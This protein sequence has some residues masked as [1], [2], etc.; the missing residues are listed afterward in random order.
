MRIMN[1]SKYNGETKEIGKWCEDNNCYLHIT[2]NIFGCD[3]YRTVFGSH[4]N[5]S[6]VKILRLPEGIHEISE[7]SFIG[8]NWDDLETIMVPTSIMKIEQGSMRN[9]VRLI[10]PICT[11]KEV[12]NSLIENHT[13]FFIEFD[14]SIDI[15]E[16]IVKIEAIMSDIIKKIHI[17][18]KLSPKYRMSKKDMIVSIMSRCYQIQDMY[19]DNVISSIDV[20]NLTNRMIGYLTTAITLSNQ[21]KEIERRM[22]K[23]HNTMMIRSYEIDIYR[24]IYRKYTAGIIKRNNMYYDE[25]LIMT[26]GKGYDQMDKK[27]KELER[28][29]MSIKYFDFNI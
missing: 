24:D 18:H 23:R 10:I 27:I 19:D 13:N 14:S 8:A 29:M 15:D 4:I 16:N 28:I 5:S 21:Y 25:E 17:T 6:R 20:S 9:S 11:N 2:K 3:E 22:R 26:F 12:I 1:Y 7:G